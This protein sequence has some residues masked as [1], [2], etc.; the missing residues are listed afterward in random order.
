MSEHQAASGFRQSSK[1]TETPKE[2]HDAN[3]DWRVFSLSEEIPGFWRFLHCGS[4]VVKALDW[5]PERHEFKSLYYQVAPAGP[6][7]EALN[8]RHLNHYG[9]PFK[10]GS[11]QGFF[12]H[13]LSGFFFSFPHHRLALY[14]FN[15]SGYILTNWIFLYAHKKL[16]CDDSEG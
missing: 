10:S 6:L 3:D 9:S 5:W 11:S 2:T 14:R 1:K 4:S 16:L 13:V 12:A 8:R 7:S 15:I